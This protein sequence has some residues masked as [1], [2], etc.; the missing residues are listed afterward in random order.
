MGM[1]KEGPIK[2]SVAAPTG[3]IFLV[4]AAIVLGVP[5][6]GCREAPDSEPVVEEAPDPEPIVEEAPDPEPS[7]EE[8]PDPEPG[9]DETPD[10]EPTVVGRRAGAVDSIW[11]VPKL[12]NLVDPPP[13]FPVA[14]MDSKPWLCTEDFGWPYPPTGERRG[15]TELHLPGSGEVRADLVARDGRFIPD[16]ECRTVWVHRERVSQLGEAMHRAT[17]SDSPS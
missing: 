8:V 10:P 16:P 1:I 6:Q 4:V 12:Y 11:L 5:L 13:L 7:V 14:W 17:Q 3:I 9:L 15:W 2:G